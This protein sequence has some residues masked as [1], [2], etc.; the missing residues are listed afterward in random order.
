MFEAGGRQWEPQAQVI[1]NVKDGYHLPQVQACIQQHAH[2]VVAYAIVAVLDRD[3]LSVELQFAGEDEAAA[4]LKA[5]GRVRL[6]KPR[7]RAET[8]GRRLYTDRMYVLPDGGELWLFARWDRRRR[9]GKVIAHRNQ[10]GGCTLVNKIVDES[11]LRGCRLVPR[12]EEPW[13]PPRLGER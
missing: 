11:V 9:I 8:R 6:H 4:F 1:T 13:R 5:Y 10:D 7:P 3:T 12:G 2:G